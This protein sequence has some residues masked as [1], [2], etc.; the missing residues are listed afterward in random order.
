[1]VKQNISI[2]V[3]AF[4]EGFVAL[5]NVVKT[6]MNNLKGYNEINANQ[7]Q[8]LAANI[9]ARQ[10]DA[11]LYQTT[12]KL[13]SSSSEQYT[14]LGNEIATA[15]KKSVGGILK[16]QDAIREQSQILAE[17]IAQRMKGTAVISTNSRNVGI[18]D[19]KLDNARKA[20]SRFNFSW[21]SVMFAGMALN[22]VFGGLIK[23][24]MQLFGV[25]DLFGGVLTLVLLP[26]MQLLLPFF[27]WLAEILMNLSPETKTLIGVM[28]ILGAIFGIVLL[29]VGQVMLAV[30]GL[31][32]IFGLAG[33]AALIAI[34]GVV[35]ILIGLG[36]VIAGIITIVRNWGEDWGKVIKGMIM[37]VIGLGIITLGVLLVMAAA[38]VAT[39]TIMAIAMTAG[40]ILIIA[41]I[42]LFVAYAITHWEEVKENWKLLWAIMENIFITAWNYI[43]TKWE[44]GI[45]D[46]IRMVNVLLPKKYEIGFVSL[47]GYKKELNDINALAKEIAIQRAERER[48]LEST[49]AKEGATSFIGKIVPEEYQGMI[50]GGTQNNQEININNS[51]TFN[52]SDKEEMQKMLDENNIKLVDDIKR[53]VNP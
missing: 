6:T 27:L 14:R 42:A 22:R 24:Q 45:N 8:I 39:A 21:L 44:K 29:V 51:N 33:S 11:L 26:I 30:Q 31:G 9:Q 20:A 10:K 37:V 36:F 41:A 17:N 52:V 23:S 1:M 13:L 2:Y 32:S 34:L 38:G 19:K 49:K 25:T 47:S 46:I 53:Q 28:I 15:G 4:Q 3:R 16:E 40:I 50:G 35:V 48:A 7:S 5:N 12:G 43:I 18:L